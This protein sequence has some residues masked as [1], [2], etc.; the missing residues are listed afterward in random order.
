MG[1]KPSKEDR[2]RYRAVHNKNFGR[3]NVSVPREDYEELKALAAKRGETMTD[4]V[5]TLI[6][7]GQDSMNNERS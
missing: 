1:W 2:V 5:L 7:W 3:L 4:L 6:T